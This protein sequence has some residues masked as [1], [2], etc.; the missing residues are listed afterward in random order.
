MR[1]IKKWIGL[2]ILYSCCKKWDTLNLAGNLSLLEKDF[3]EPLI[4]TVGCRVHM[5]GLTLRWQQFSST[6]IFGWS[7]PC[8]ML[9]YQVW[10]GMPALD[11]TE[12]WQNHFKYWKSRDSIWLPNS[13][14]EFKF[15]VFPLHFIFSAHLLNGTLVTEVSLVWHSEGQNPSQQPGF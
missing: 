5:P 9:L 2:Y 6:N 11:S 10:D 12:N 7:A 15:S 14:C 4:E 13:C 8:S 3:R 1:E